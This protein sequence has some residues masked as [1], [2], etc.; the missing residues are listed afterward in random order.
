MNGRWR[1]RGCVYAP[2]SVALHPKLATHA[3]NPLPVHL[4]GDVYRVFYSGRD[5]ANRSSVGAVDV[6]VVRGEVVQVHAEPFFVHGPPGSF[7]EAGVS[8]GCLHTVGEQTWMLF[9][10]WQT[11]EGGHWRGD[12]GALRVGNDLSLSLDGD[13]PWMGVDATD[14]MSLSY[15]WSLRL[16]DGTWRLWY[17]STLAWDAGNGEMLHV[18]NAATSVDGRHWTREGLSV[19]FQLGRAQAFSRPTVVVDDRGGFDMWFSYRGAPGC[20][21]RIGRARSADGLA[22]CLCLDEAGIDVSA[23]GWDSEMVEYPFVWTHGG[24]RYMLYN[25]NGHGRSGF[26][27]AQW[28]GD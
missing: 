14:P 3:A 24:Q 13:R 22:W 9:M 27:L 21:Y 25:G 28:E 16:A 6:D 5:S 4:A 1:K 19:P 10:G 26:G 18:I 12:I 11:P 17:G 15:P 2:P 7:F 23:D 20:A 8:I